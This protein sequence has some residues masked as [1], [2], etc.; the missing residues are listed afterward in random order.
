[1]NL[2]KRLLI[3]AVLL[4]IVGWGAY[5][6]EIGLDANGVNMAKS[7]FNGLTHPETELFNLTNKGIPYLILETIA[8]AFLS[9]VIGTLLAIPVSFLSST[10][11]VPRPVALVFR[12]I[13]LFI[14]TIPSLVWALIWVRVTSTG[15]FC[16]VVTQSVCSIGMISKMN[17]TAIENLDTG[18]LEALDACGANTF[19]KIR[20]GVLPQLSAS[21]VS[22][23]IYRFDIN[24][25][26]ATLLGI[27][28]AG[29]IGSPLND[30]IGNMRWNR[31][32]AFLI[33][34]IVMVVV[35]EFVSTR[36]RARLAQG[37]R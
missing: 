2:W 23:A 3:L 17:V 20:V 24:L 31:V 7:I 6:F 13:V 10:N 4:V 19:E 14:R 26:D 30:A 1:K 37:R 18:V 34:L 8:I 11:I 32:G 25:K 9:T 12:A 35:I 15:P 22:T 27:V 16:G 21:F 5:G 33:V 29:G 36:I 28:G